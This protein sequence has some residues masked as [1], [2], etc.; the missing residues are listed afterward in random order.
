MRGREST[1]IVSAD[2]HRNKLRV[3]STAFSLLRGLGLS[4]RRRVEDGGDLGLVVLLCEHDRRVAAVGLCAR[5]GTS[6]EERLPLHDSKQGGCE[7]AWW[8]RT[9]GASSAAAHLDAVDP[10]VAHGEMQRRLLPRRDWINGV[11][12]CTDASKS[13]VVF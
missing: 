4:L 12:R 6:V 3:L 1:I 5:R 7:H 9:A 11:S 13:Q 10:S 2:R 8:L